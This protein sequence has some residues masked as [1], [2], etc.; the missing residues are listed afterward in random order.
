M[1]EVFINRVDPLQRF[2]ELK[3]Q[4]GEGQETS[5]KSFSELLN[6]AL[7]EVNQ[8]QKVSDENISKV[9]SGEIKDVHSA[10]IAMQKAD[11]SFQLVLQVRNKL[12]EAYREVM[13]MQV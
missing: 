10:M 13:R 4:T 7:G 2:N 5:S 1:S 9:L 12:V 3:Q 8:L 6:E 11:L